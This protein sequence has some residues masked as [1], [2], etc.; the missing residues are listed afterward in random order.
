MQDL[1]TSI[2]RTKRDGLGFR[3]KKNYKLQI[4]SLKFGV[5]WILYPKVLE[6]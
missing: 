6:T 4:T 1:P 2:A 5:Y 3:V